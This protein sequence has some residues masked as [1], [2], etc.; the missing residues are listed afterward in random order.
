M[1]QNLPG[2]KNAA[3]L[4]A[5]PHVS[6]IPFGGIYAGV[7]LISSAYPIASVPPFYPSLLWD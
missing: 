6:L 7:A 2:N 5:P 3:P 4:L 1:Q